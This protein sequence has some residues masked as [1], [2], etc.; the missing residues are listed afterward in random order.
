MTG[1]FGSLKEFADAL[2]TLPE[3]HQQA[4]KRASE[5]NALLTK[6][7]GALGRLEDISIWY[8]G[9]RGNPKANIEN[10]QV[11]VFAGNHGV[12][13]KGVSAFPTEVTAQ[14]VANFDAGG[15]AINQLAKSAGAELSVL[16]LE[17]DTPTADFTKGPAMSDEECTDALSAG[18]QAVDPSADALVVGEM[19]IGN[20]TSAAAVCLA[21]F[22]GDAADWT[23]AG[24]GLDGHA[25]RHKTEVV[26]KGVNS[27]SAAK[28][29][30]LVALTALGGR[31]LAAMAGAIVAARMHSIPVVLDGFIC[32]AAAACLEVAK[33]GALNHTIAGHLSSEAAHSRLLERL[34]KKPLLDLGMR[35]G[36][37]SGG[38]LALNILR[39]ALACHS[40]MATFE[41]AGVSD[42]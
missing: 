6:P 35:L 7:Q 12:A 34:G 40:G 36:E 26:T 14:M 38:A 19:G 20:T 42:G 11:I 31:E 10:P 30:G 39:A 3:P 2:Q 33:R 13:T 17:L 21:L 16:A 28:N 9:W 41:E 24:T 32:C 8:C 23:G 22:G 15:A 29:D 1:Q 25:L 18:W 5:R 4:S 37:G 27:N